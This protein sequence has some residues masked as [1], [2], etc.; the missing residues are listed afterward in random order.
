MSGANSLRQ[1]ALKNPLVHENE[2]EE[3]MYEIEH[4]KNQNQEG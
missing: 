2:Y 1:S 3:L 4:L